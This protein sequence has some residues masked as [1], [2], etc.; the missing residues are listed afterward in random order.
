MSDSDESTGGAAIGTQIWIA[1]ESKSK[2]PKSPK[3]P[4][5]LFRIFEYGLKTF[6]NLRSIL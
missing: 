2:S 5:K 3:S 6:S 1:P 4:K